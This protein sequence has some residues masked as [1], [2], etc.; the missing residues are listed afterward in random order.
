MGLGE[1]GRGPH[2]VEGGWPGEPA[3]AADEGVGVV[4]E[5]RR[6]HPAAGRQGRQLAET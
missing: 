6:H 1:V 2:P 5:H 4:L 3:L